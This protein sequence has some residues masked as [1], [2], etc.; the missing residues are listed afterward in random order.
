MSRTVCAACLLAC[1]GVTSARVHTQT[2]ADRTQDRVAFP[3]HTIIGNVHYVGTATLNAYLVTTPQGHI[4]INTNYEDTVPL[5]RASVEKLGFAFTDIKIVLGSHAHPDH[6]QADGMVKE[7]TGGAT[8]M[9]MEQDVPAL[10]GMKAPSGR[11]HPIDRV[12]KDAEQVSLGGTTLVARLTPGHKRGCTTWTMR[13]AD[14]GRTYDVVIACAGLQQGAQLVNNK[15]YPEIADDFARSLKTFKSL[16]ADVFL[17]AHSWFFDLAG[18]Y[19]KLGGA[20]NPYVDPGGYKTWVDNQER[21]YSSTLA[22]Q[23]KSAN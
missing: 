11:P 17:G 1:L 13:I 9:A 18:K 7:L 10:K 5:L 19:T 12:L 16:P 4:L 3:A 22:A 20:A 21:N 2:Q 14:G 23:K 6:M 8:V 15:A